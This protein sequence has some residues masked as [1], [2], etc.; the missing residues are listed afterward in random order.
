M[1]FNTSLKSFYQ[2]AQITANKSNDQK[3]DFLTLLEEKQMF[4]II[5]KAN[6]FF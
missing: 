4:F 1:L 6:N 3:K 5:S 2:P